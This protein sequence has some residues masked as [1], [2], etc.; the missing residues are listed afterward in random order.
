MIILFKMLLDMPHLSSGWSIL[1][2]EKHFLSMYVY[3]AFRKYS[4]PFTFSTFYVTNINLHTMYP[5]MVIEIF[6]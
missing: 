5:I 3:G 6:V 4:D 1:E 2:K